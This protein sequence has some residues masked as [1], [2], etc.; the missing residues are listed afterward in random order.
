MHSDR[1]VRRA[2]AFVAG[3]A[4]QILSRKQR[5]PNDV[6][7]VQNIDRNR[8][9]P[10][11]AAALLFLAAEQYADANEA[12]AGIIPNREGQLYQA[13]IL[14]EH[15][16][17]LAKG[18][19][20]LII[21]R[22]KIWRNNNRKVDH[23]ETVALIA[24]LESLIT[25]IEMLA[26]KILAMPL[27]DNIDTNF[28]DARHAFTTVL[29]L[30]L[31]KSSQIIDNFDGGFS[32]SYSGPQHLASL[33]I[34]AHDGIHEAAITNIPPPPGSDNGFWQRWVAYRAKKFPFVWPNHR[35][36]IE[37]GFHESGKSAV[38]VLPTGA[39]KTTVSSLKI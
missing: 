15:V 22:S 23:L 32:I 16:L 8:V 4:Q 31:K 7:I 5:T 12:A 19:L 34:A 30:S 21:D 29:S 14:S 26:A 39:G 38:L 37:Q 3:T 35:K 10:T 33:L 2:S 27:P 24:L 28:N 18:R 13:T 9:D 20:N 6:E 36:A 17:N 11:I 1:T 25:G